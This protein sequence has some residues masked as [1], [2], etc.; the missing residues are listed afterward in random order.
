MLGSSPP[1][2]S[3]TTYLWQ[4]MR[5]SML[6]LM[7]NLRSHSSQGKEITDADI[8]RGAKNKVKKADKTSQMESFKDKSLSNGT[9][10]LELLGAVEPRVVNWSLVT[11]GETN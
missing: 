11:K 2:I 10:F 3:P 4:L 1:F 9:F 7:K 5:F 6:Q 8:L